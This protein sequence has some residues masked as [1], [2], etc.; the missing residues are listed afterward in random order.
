MITTKD[1]LIEK[2]ESINACD[3]AITY[4]KTQPDLQTAW[5]N[6][7]PSYLWWL[8]RNTSGVTPAQSVEFANVSAKYARFI[9]ERAAEWADWADRA[10]RAAEWAAERAAEWAD[11]ADRA[12]R[13][14]RAGIETPRQYIN[15]HWTMKKVLRALDK[16]KP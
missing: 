11:W 7:K 12:D 3:G 9:A 16:K 6:C 2:L 4:L 14:D 13:A 15:K 8:I 1:E 10:D 5:D